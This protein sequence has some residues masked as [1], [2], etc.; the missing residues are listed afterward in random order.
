MLKSPITCITKSQLVSSGW[1]ISKLLGALL[2]LKTGLLLVKLCEILA[3]TLEYKARTLGEVE[4]Y[5]KN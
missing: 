5:L 3:M 2:L 4:S 1:D